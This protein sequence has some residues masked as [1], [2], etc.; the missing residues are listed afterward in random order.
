MS[1]HRKAFDPNS[2]GR[3]PLNL[4]E[5]EL[6]KIPADLFDYVQVD[7]PYIETCVICS[8]VIETMCYKQ[9]GIC[10]DNCRKLR[11]SEDRKDGKH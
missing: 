8:K 1:K 4:P 6:F 10:S 5:L 9:T 2:N 7:A 3:I 11:D